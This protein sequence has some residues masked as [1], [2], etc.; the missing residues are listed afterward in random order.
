MDSMLGSLSKNK[1]QIE[2][3]KAEY[4]KVKATSINDMWIEDLSALKKEM[5]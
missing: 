2:D 1:K 5:K 3:G 4:A